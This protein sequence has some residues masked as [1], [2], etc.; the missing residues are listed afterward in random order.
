[1]ARRR[2]LFSVFVVVLML[3][4]TLPCVLGFAAFPLAKGDLDAS[5]GES[6]AII[7]GV[8]DYKYINDLNYCDDDAIGLY[9]QIAASWG[10]DHVRLLIDANANKTN[11]H[12]AIFN[13]LDPA[14]D[15]N[16]TVL[17][18]FSGHGGQG[19]DVSPIDE[20]D[21]KTSTYVPMI[22]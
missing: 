9:N 14:E 4:I 6:W 17:F 11:I 7:V 15:E 20:A 12:D 22:L 5:N 8:S 13:W 16:D 21:G 3:V 19:T 1:M 18:F 10:A 2:S